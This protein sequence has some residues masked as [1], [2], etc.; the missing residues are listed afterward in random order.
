MNQR[1]SFDYDNVGSEEEYQTVSDRLLFGI[2]LLA[3]VFGVWALAVFVLGLERI[4]GVPKLSAYRHPSNKVPRKHP[5]G[6]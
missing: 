6:R 3:T 1:I 5:R 4:A 2:Q